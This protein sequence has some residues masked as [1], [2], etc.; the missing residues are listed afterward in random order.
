MQELDY[1]SLNV[2]ESINAEIRG[3]SR[4]GSEP[5]TCGDV[6]IGYFHTPYS[7]VHS[8]DTVRYVR[9]VVLVLMFWLFDLQP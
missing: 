1:R 8:M 3:Q 5:T 9:T 6:T 7:G 2:P 4:K